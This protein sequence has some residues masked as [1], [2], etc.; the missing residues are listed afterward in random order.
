MKLTPD[1]DFC[2]V[3]HYW[4]CRVGQEIQ[5]ALAGVPGAYAEEKRVKHELDEHLAH[6]HNNEPEGNQ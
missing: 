4:C 3:C 2:Q 5:R 1:P 6:T